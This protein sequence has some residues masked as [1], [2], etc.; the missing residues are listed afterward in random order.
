MDESNKTL[1][2]K[3]N[4]RVSATYFG[5]GNKEESTVY[6]LRNE[7]IHGVL[8]K[9][10]LGNSPFGVIHCFYELFGPEKTKYFITAITRLCLAYLK[11][12]GFST[13]MNDLEL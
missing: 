7:L 5:K 4:A 13:D 2:H 6:F 8:D 12:R 3:Y 1:T 10:S 11:R 9:N